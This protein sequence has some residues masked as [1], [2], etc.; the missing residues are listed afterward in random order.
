MSLIIGMHPTS[1][2]KTTAKQSQTQSSLESLEGV[3]VRWSSVLLT[4]LFWCKVG[5]AHLF[6]LLE[7]LLDVELHLAVYFWA[8]HLPERFLDRVSDP[9]LSLL[10][11]LFVWRLFRGGWSFSW[12]LRAILV[13]V[14]LKPLRD[15]QWWPICLTNLHVVAI[16]LFCNPLVN[17]DKSLRPQ[18]PSFIV[19]SEVKS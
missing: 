11:L 3:S 7:R 1:K 18:A 17:L 12:Y 8:S 2:R 6:F 16:L 14:V 15:R 5:A 13:Q 4:N 19:I 10:L 9:F